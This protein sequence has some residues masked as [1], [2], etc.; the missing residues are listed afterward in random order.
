MF[1][2]VIYTQHNILEIDGDQSFPTWLW[3][4]WIKDTF[5]LAPLYVMSLPSPDRFKVCTSLRFGHFNLNTMSH[6]MD[7]SLGAG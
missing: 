4:Y 2:L 1:V 5:D 3:A 7:V 6:I